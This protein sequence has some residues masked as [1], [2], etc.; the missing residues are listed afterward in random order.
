MAN[1]GIPGY[2]SRGLEGHRASYL[3]FVIA[4]F[5]GRRVAPQEMFGWRGPLLFLMI[6]EN[7]GLYCVT[8]LWRSL[9]G[10]RTVGLLFRPL[11]AA[12]AK[13]WRLKLKRA[14]L[15]ALRYVPAVQTLSIVPVPLVPKIGAIV[16]SWIHDFQ[17][18]DL[19]ESESARFEEIR[20]PSTQLARPAPIFTEAKHFA[21]GR[22]LL[23]ALGMQNQ[24]KG[25]E[26]LAASMR[27]GGTKDWAVLVAGRFAP[28]AAHWRIAIEAHGGH[29]VDRFLSDDEML[30]LYAAADAIWCLYDPSYDQA[31]GILGRAI[32]L[33]IPPIVRTGS[34]SES[35][36]RAESIFHV[37]A[38]GGRDLNTALIKTL[39][40]DRDISKATYLKVHRIQQNLA[41][42]RTA[43]QQSSAETK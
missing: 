35:F 5:G 37:S 31:S 19:T 3:A 23:I 28:E 6:E 40:E 29:I 43:L 38:E 22:P 33:G 41:R 20:T 9:L 25:A 24:A 2:Y 27:E 1:G 10:R 13:S 26:R 17:L 34:L 11:P 32:Q 14:V 21:K 42:L 7:F 30:A 16:D 39:I 36:C 15:R 12:E 8:G 4:R 18:W